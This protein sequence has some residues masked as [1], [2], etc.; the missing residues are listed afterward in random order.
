MSH[1]THVTGVF[2]T[3]NDGGGGYTDEEKKFILNLE[4]KN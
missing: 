1:W 3:Q 4:T 2:R